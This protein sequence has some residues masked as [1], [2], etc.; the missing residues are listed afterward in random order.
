MSGAAACALAM[1]ALSTLAAALY[2]ADG[3]RALVTAWQVPE[4]SHGPLIP[5]L[6]GLLFLRHL[7]RVPAGRSDLRDRW[8]GVLVICAALALGGLGRLS[9]IEDLVAYAIILWIAGVILIGFGWR[10]GRQ[11]WPAVLHLV[12]ML[13]LPGV[14][15]FKLTTG[16]QLV[17][18]EIG[19]LI[20]RGFGIPVFLDGNIIDLG[21]MRLHVAEACSGL[22]YLFPILSFSYIFA[23]LY[24]GPVW[25]KALLL[26]SAAPIAVMMNALRIALA[27]IL[28]QAY[29][30]DWVTGFTHFF[31]GWVVFLAC[32]AVLFCLAWGLV[33]LHPGRTTL[34][35]ALDL[36][37]SG[38]IAQVARLRNLRTNGA[39]VLSTLA[40]L[41]SLGLAA[42][43]P[44]RDTLTIG[45]DPF[46]LFPQTLGAWQQT[47]ARR[48]LP[49]A[50]A[51]TLGADD[52]HLA[53]YD[54]EE[55]WG[56]VDLFLAWY[57]DQGQGGVHSPEICLP[58]AGW[59]IAW[60]ERTD[61][62]GHVGDSDPFRINRA[63]IQRG[64]QRMM[65]YYWFEQKGRRIA[66]DFAAKAQ[67]VVDGVRTGRTDGALV[68]LTTAIATGEAPA[69]AEARLRDFVADL[70]GPLLRFIP[71]TGP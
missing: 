13:P 62:A 28:V 22:R 61:I 25:H 50:I 23:A 14:V 27:G 4:Y 31:E 12:Y 60:L 52:Y 20:L 33:R 58:G 39:W 35:D 2:F 71:G 18:S 51:T 42:S 68:R 5:V 17:S 26:V 19:T 15:Y 10:R 47:G 9:R 48:V 64:E 46:G 44:P 63:V 65:V 3:L 59:E 43:V 45:R 6:S 7:R 29:G 69:A 67:L 37:T 1:L 41:A 70:M 54:S 40:V 49:P 30:P 34:A 57:A 32:V 55:G 36:E 21:V 24:R 53:T 8:V 38:C 56:Q 66:W 11:F 16:L